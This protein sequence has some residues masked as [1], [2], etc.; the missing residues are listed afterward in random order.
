MGQ[1]QSTGAEEHYDG[2]EG[3]S[4]PIGKVT[5]WYGGY[6][7]I[8]PMYGWIPAVGAVLYSAPAPEQK[9]V[10]WMLMNDT[11]CHIMATDW[12][13]E[14]S[15][16]WKTAP[17]YTVPPARKSLTDEEIDNL[18]LPPNGCTMRELVRAIERAHG[19]DGGHDCWR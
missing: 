6:P 14:D 13:P 4:K 15:D 11:Q 9:P 18:E 5:G 8:D 3:M 2:K 7:V 16:G 17:L 12:K 10:A 1:Q 19:I